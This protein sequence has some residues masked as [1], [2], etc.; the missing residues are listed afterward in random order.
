M[1]VVVGLG[2]PGKRY[3]S[4]RHNVGF[5]VVRDLAKRW[6]TTG[7]RVQNEAVVVDGNFG[8]ER[9]LLV[10][11]QTFMNLSG[12]S[13]AGLC[14]FYKVSPEQ[15]LVVCDDLNLP[16]GRLRIRVG[17]SAGGQKGLDNI[18]LLLGTQE[19]PRLRV[20]IGSPPGRM[21]AAAFVLQR[22]DDNESQ[23]MQDAVGSAGA[24][25]ECWITDGIA[26]AMNRFNAAG[27]ASG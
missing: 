26:T 25:V 1:R 10:Q 17:G 13:V 12:R 2:N 22:F 11:P 5:D 23:R 24:A 18:L 9:V 16:L 21:D 20:G 14:A 3:E 15:V 6:Q 7:E 8:G 27:P 19:V 4:T